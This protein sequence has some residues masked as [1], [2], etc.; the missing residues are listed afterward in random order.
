MSK[1]SFPE[2]TTSKASP[3]PSFYLGAW[4][5][6]KQSMTRAALKKVDFSRVDCSNVVFSSGQPMGALI[7]EQHRNAQAH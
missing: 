6:G 4:E 1:F 5:S 2:N 7:P 3:D